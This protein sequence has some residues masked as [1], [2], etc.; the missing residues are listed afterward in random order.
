MVPERELNFEG[1][2]GP[3]VASKSNRNRAK[4]R[5]ET[6]R[7]LGWVLDGS[8]DRFWTILDPSG[9]QVGKL[10]PGWHQNSTKIPFWS[11]DGSKTPKLQSR[12]PKVAPRHPKLEPK[13]LPRPPNW[14]QNSKRDPQLRANNNKNS[15]YYSYYLL[16]AYLLPTTDY[17][18]VKVGVNR[19]ACTIHM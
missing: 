13:C 3:K 12:W 6:R 5:S 10:G 8:W 2:R 11:Q 19:D 1:F 16:P 7:K 15:N 4:K 18:L 17:L 14:N 9:G